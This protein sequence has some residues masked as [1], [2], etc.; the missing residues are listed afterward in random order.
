MIELVA[1]QTVKLLGHLVGRLDSFLT[2]DRFHCLG[3]QRTLSFIYQLLFVWLTNIPFC[4]LVAWPAHIFLIA[5]PNTP[6]TIL[7]QFLET[8]LFFQFTASLHMTDLVTW[9][10]AHG[11]LSRAT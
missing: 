8:L 7:L 1:W 5:R 3:L 9:L 6:H 4:L 2:Q 10:I 11:S